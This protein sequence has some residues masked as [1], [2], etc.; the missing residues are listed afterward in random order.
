MSE[1]EK[2]LRKKSDK[3]QKQDKNQSQ[4]ATCEQKTTSVKGN[5]VQTK[6]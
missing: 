1:L 4:K 2:Q 6:N 5:L 3:K